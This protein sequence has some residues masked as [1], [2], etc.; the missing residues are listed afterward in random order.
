ML[1][2]VLFS[3]PLLITSD[4]VGLDEKKGHEEEVRVHG[5]LRVTDFFRL[6][7]TPGDL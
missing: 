1:C 6:E 7:G 4:I 5:Q 3:A 2:S